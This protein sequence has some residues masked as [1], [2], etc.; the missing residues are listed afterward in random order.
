LVKKG[1]AVPL[2]AGVVQRVPGS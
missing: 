2:E 1:K